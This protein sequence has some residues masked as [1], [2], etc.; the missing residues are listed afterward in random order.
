MLAGLF[1]FMLGACTPAQTG[2]S[3]ESLDATE[4][5]AE[6]TATVVVAEATADAGGAVVT[7][8]VVTEDQVVVVDEA[9]VVTDTIPNNTTIGPATSG[10][11]T[12]SDLL[13]HNFTNP[14]STVNG[15]VQNVLL[16]F[17]SGRVLF[18]TLEYG[19]FLDIGD[20]E[21]PVPL[22]AFQLGT[23]NELILNFDETRLDALPDLGGDWPDL[24]DA[25]WDDEIVQFWREATFDPGFDFE[26]NT[27][28]IIWLSDLIDQPVGDIGFGEGQVE[29]ILIDVGQSRIKYIVLN[30]GPLLGE[31]FVALPFSALNTQV[32]DGN[33]QLGAAL[34]A[35]TLSAAPQITTEQLNADSFDPTLDEE[36]SRYWTDRGFVVEE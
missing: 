10:L 36:A 12:G 21:I 3:N 4:A 5:A 35:D 32:Y 7:D 8:D 34:D 1:L 9:A 27:S 6:L 26:N 29:D 14:S 28:I 30:Y 2:I 24:T 25:S 18:V 16:D 13:D 22:N 19:G 23:D 20:T 15:E 17:S 31:Q 33:V 11:L